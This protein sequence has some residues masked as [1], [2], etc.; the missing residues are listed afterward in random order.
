M[1]SV[2]FTYILYPK[3]IYYQSE[4]NRSCFMVE[5]ARCVLG[6]MVSVNLE[7][8]LQKFVGESS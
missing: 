5:Q 8:F 4:P 6:L 1:F 3:I 7:L 2:L